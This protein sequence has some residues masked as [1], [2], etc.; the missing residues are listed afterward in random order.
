MRFAFDN[1]LQS[2]PL[3]F[4]ETII[5]SSV[6][7]K[8]LIF[9]LIL[10]KII[11][12]CYTFIQV[13]YGKIRIIVAKMT[14]NC[15]SSFISCHSSIVL[16]HSSLIAH[17]QSSYHSPTCQNIDCHLSILPHLSENHKARCEENVFR[18]A[19]VLQFLHLQ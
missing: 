6:I 1:I 8:I 14:R 12:T 16:V 7:R 17:I 13:L 3:R 4:N 11:I 18:D 10:L 15:Y 2:C 5:R 19:R 9:I